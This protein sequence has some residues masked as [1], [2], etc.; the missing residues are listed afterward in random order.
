M[1]RSDSSPQTVWQETLQQGPIKD[2][3][4]KSPATFWWHNPTNH[5]SLRLTYEAYSAIKHSVKFYKFQL[6]KDLLPKTFIQLERYFKEPYYVQNRKTIHIVSERD[7]MM[8]ALHA[9]DLQKY[10]D[11]LSL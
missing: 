11:D 3:Y 8:L 2:R 1:S 7:S 10:L 6:A 4:L 5:N 9:N